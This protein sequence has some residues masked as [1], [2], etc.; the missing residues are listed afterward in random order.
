MK[1][2]LIALILAFTSSI[3][4]AELTLDFKANSD[5][6]RSIIHKKEEWFFVVKAATYDVYI[7]KAIVGRKQKNIEFHAV[8][9]FH[10]LQTYSQLPFEI[11]RIYTYGVLS[12]EQEKLYLLNDLFTD[13]NNIIRYTQSHEFGS[14]VTNLD[15]KN[16]IARNVYDVVCGDTI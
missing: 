2:V 1:N 7:D 8:T 3:S 6:T 15:V 4:S 14:Y 5:S 9:E 12:C 13:Q 10:N 11:K 16:S